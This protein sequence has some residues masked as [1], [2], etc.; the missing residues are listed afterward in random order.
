MPLI[1]ELLSLEKSA[2]EESVFAA[3]A[4]AAENLKIKYLG[5]KGLLAGLTQ[6]LGE[7][8]PEERP[9]AGRE[10]NR[11]KN[12][13]QEL[14]D[15][16]KNAAA[17]AAPDSHNAFDLTMPGTAVKPG[18]AHPITQ[19]IDE[20]C[21]IFSDLGFSIV[22]GPEMETEWHN[23]DALNAPANHISREDT[24]YLDNGKILRSQ[25]STVQIRVMEKCKPP[26]RIVSPG[27]VYRP[28]ATDATHSFMFHQIEGLLVDE[29]AAFSDLKG[30]LTQFLQTF[31][32]KKV[33]M[34]FRPHYFPFTEPS[35]EAD[36]SNDLW[37]GEAA[38]AAKKDWLEILGAG[39]VHPNVLRAVKINPDRYRGLAFGLGVER[40]AMLRWGIKDI[41]HFYEN[42]IRFLRQFA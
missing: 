20:I 28:D 5:R 4:E 12:A 8:S 36:I 37:R 15:S 26:I 24:Y 39:M 30:I 13:L 38:N 35:L 22:F 14:F 25:T 3:N 41:R 21:D 2:R 18:A 1:D 7:A 17:S 16:L 10:A 34:R 19:V 27:R 33:K 6:R 9:A 29:K 32:G 31:F 40:M 11:I 42:D 23:F